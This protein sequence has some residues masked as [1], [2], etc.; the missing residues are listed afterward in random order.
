[1][2]PVLLL[3]VALGKV[4]MSLLLRLMLGNEMTD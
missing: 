3:T 1:M 2:A 4:S